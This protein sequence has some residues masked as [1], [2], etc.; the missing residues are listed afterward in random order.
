MLLLQG[1]L[2]HSF[3]GQSLLLSTT[4]PIENLNYKRL[5][6]KTIFEASSLSSEN[7]RCQVSV[8]IYHLCKDTYDVLFLT[9]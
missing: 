9:K 2:N 5:D 1:F 6:A 3:P 8:L 7:E 4:V